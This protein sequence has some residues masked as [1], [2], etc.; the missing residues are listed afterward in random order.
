[1]QQISVPRVSPSRHELEQYIKAHYG[2]LLG[3]HDIRIRKKMQ[4]ISK[5]D[6]PH[7]PKPWGEFLKEEVTDAQR[8]LEMERILATPLDPDARP[9]DHLKLIHSLQQLLKDNLDWMDNEIDRLDREQ[10]DLVSLEVFQENLNK[11]LRELQKA[12][13]YGL[14]ED[15]ANIDIKSGGIPSLE[16]FSDIQKDARTIAKYDQLTQTVLGPNP[17]PAQRLLLIHSLHDALKDDIRWLEKEIEV[18][19]REFV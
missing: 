8:L 13:R 19:D 1:V 4:D 15:I 6:I 12:R 2:A 5:V 10:G 16:G 11:T 3:F 9:A 7:G 14:L 18:L 17:Q